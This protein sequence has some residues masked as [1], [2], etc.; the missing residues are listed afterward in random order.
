M[1]YNLFLFFVFTLK[2]DLFV[3]RKHKGAF[4]DALRT[5]NQWAS[6]LKLDANRR[7]V[8][9]DPLAPSELSAQRSHSLMPLGLPVP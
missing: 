1:I 9:S 4:I 6:P 8:K 2:F 7:A 3:C 5:R